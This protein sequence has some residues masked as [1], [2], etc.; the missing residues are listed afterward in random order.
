MLSDLRKTKARRVIGLDCSTNSLA[1]AVFEG[2]T[3]VM[4]GEVFF[5]GADIY[6][7]LNDARRKTQMLVD[8]GILVGDYVGIE[9]AVAVKN[10]QVVIKLAYVYGAVMGV[11]M[12]N[13]MKV[14][15]VAPITWQSAIGNPNLKKEEKDKIRKDNP[16]KSTTWYASEGRRIRKNRTL[17]F[18]RD[19][20]TIESDSDN[21]GDAVGIAWYVTK[22][23]THR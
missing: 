4:T 3:P 15:T 13:K 7:R 11:L 16:G 1:F 17:D 14:E 21:V 18:A 10:V 19:Y 12:Q 8:Q 22:H 20:F 6:E 5:Q 23:L 9:S 2:E